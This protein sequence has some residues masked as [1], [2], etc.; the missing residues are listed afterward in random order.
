MIYF[1][2]SVNEIDIAEAALLA[3]LPKAPSK[4]NPY[5]KNNLAIK[6]KDWV[7]NRMYDNKFIDKTTLIKEKKKN[8]IRK[9]DY[10]I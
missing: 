6:R 3:S 7:L 9:K 5:K 1:D 8:I 2:K 10:I 4:Y